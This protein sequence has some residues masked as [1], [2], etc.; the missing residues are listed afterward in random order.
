MPFQAANCSDRFASKEW[1]PPAGNISIPAEVVAVPPVPVVA[2]H[3]LE[4][5][6]VVPDVVKP[7]DNLIV[8]VPVDASS[9]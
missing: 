8:A 1:S 4:T 2:L 6:V 9:D 7:T 5:S 3:H